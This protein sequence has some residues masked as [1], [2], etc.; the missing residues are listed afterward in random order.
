MGIYQRLVK[1]GD[2]PYHFNGRFKKDP[3]DGGT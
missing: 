2:F 1:D 3:I